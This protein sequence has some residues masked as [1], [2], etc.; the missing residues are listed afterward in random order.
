MSENSFQDTLNKMAALDDLANTVQSA[1]D[2]L[3]AN[4]QNI[5]KLIGDANKQIQNLQ[6][7]IDRIK[8]Q[9]LQAKAQ[10]A[11]LV[12]SANLRQ[13][14]TI[15]K[16]KAT[17]NGMSDTKALESQVGLLKSDIDKLAVGLD[18]AGASA[19][20]PIADAAAASAKAKADAPGPY[21]PPSMRG[22]YTYGR[23]KTRGN[24]RRKRT[25]KSRK[26]GSPSK[27]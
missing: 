5:M 23:S 15:E 6:G 9:G 7:N 19:G 4:K 10:V 13:D 3:T 22:G 8:G 25:K 12:K 1:N 20:N 18:I 24:K 14:A 11:D 17:I 27:K 16:L 2:K 26:K 21:V